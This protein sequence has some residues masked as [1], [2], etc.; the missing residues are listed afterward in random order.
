MIKVVLDV[1]HGANTAGKRTPKLQSTI[2]AKYNGLELIVKKGEQ[3]KEHTAACGVAHFTEQEL[4]RYGFDVIKSGWTS[5]ANAE[6]DICPTNPTEDVIARQ[7]KINKLNA[8]YCISDHFNAS[9]DGSTFNSA[10]GQEVLCHSVA[11]KVKDSKP[12]ALAI[13]KRLKEAFPNQKARGKDGVVYGD[14]WG[15]CNAT[16]LNVKASVLIEHAFMTNQIEVENYM[17]QPKAWHDYAVAT[18]KG[19]IDYI[20]GGVPIFPITKLST[21][22]HKLWLQMILNK[23]ISDNGI[24]CEKLKLD[25]SYGNKTADTYKRFARYKGWSA[26][27]GWYVGPNGIKE[28]SR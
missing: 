23:W 12:L 4:N 16:A 11:S 27:T 25:G 3:L 17:T 18:V 1:G 21:K 15:M 19:L 22:K 28:L 10:N 2:M 20:T 24:Q 9:G 13:A 14:G 7:L 8:D 26:P 5:Y 6:K